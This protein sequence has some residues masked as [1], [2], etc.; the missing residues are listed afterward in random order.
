MEA[1]QSLARRPLSGSN[2]VT[3]YTV[4]D[5]RRL[6]LYLAHGLE[7]SYPDSCPAL[8]GALK[9]PLAR[10]LRTEQPQV[11]SIAPSRT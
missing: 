3:D 11:T 9:I 4:A 8:T 5:Y 7:R 6:T 10:F 2:F 1:E